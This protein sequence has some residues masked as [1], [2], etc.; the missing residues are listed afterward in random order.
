M[1]KYEL[2]VVSGLKGVFSIVAFTFLILFIL[3]L[4]KDVNNLFSKILISLFI[5]GLFTYLVFRFCSGKILVEQST[6]SFKFK[7]IDR[8]FLDFRKLNPIIISEIKSIVV[9][10]NGHIRKIN[11]DIFTLKVN[12]F[13][14][15][16]DEA[17]FL[18]CL[19]LVAKENNLQIIDSWDIWNEKGYLKNAYRINQAIIVILFLYAIIENY[20]KS[21]HLLILIFMVVQLISY[22]FLIKSKMGKSQ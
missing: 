13:K 15:K 17:E 2:R 1:K 14:Q 5:I 3:I 6:N 7:W 21:I 11:T 18:E 22:H 20:F 16:N 10:D 8:P 12:S 4:V 9:D 19:N